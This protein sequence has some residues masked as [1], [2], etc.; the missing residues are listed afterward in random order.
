[1]DLLFSNVDARQH[2]VIHESLGMLREIY[3][4]ASD[5]KLL[6]MAVVRMRIDVFGER[7]ENAQATPS[8]DA[9]QPKKLSELFS[10]VAES[11]G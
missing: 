6:E 10:F 2:R 8:S 11:T 7:D 5:G 3:P 4:E 1:M 9:I